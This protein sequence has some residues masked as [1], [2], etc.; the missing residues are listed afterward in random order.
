LEVDL[1]L[2]HK[3]AGFGEYLCKWWAPPGARGNAQFEGGRSHQGENRHVVQEEEIEM[4]HKCAKIHL[5]TMLSQKSQICK[6]V[7]FIT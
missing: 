5:R 1:S 7:K 6:K 4:E 2:K 3:E